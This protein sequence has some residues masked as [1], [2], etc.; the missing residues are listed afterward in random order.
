MIK[1]FKEN[2]IN[3]SIT[4]IMALLLFNA[5]LIFY[6][7]KVMKENTALKKQTEDVQSL[8]KSIFENHLRR[9]DLGLR[10]YALTKK[11]QMLKPYYDARAEMP[12]S[13]SYMDSLLVEQHL[14]DTKKQFTVFKRK[15]EGYTNYLETMRVLAEQDSIEAF[16]QLL[17]EDKGFELWNAYAPMFDYII[18]T[19]H[20]LVQRADARYQEALD[21]NVIFQAILIALTIPTLIGVMYRIRRDVRNR[22]KLLLDFEENNRTYMFNPGLTVS[23]DNQQDIIE[24]SIQNLKKASVFIKGMASGNYS[25]N[26][27]GLTPENE[28]LNQENLAGDLIKLRDEMKKVKETDEKRIWSTEGLA[29]FS[30]VAR[31][32]QNNIEKLSNEVVRFLANYLKA[33]QGS[34]FI[35]HNEEDEEPYLQMAACY[36]FEK[37]KF[38]EKRVEIGSG[39]VGQAYM[40]G[41]TILLTQVPSGYITITSGMGD[42]T[43]NC[44]IIVP[45]KYNDRVEAILE[46]AS[47]SVFQ[48]HEIEF[49]EKA[50]EV[51]ASS[52][53][54][55]KINERTTKLL[56][57]TQHQ[58]EILKAQEEELRQ[59]M[60]E[61]QATQESMR[62][63]ERERQGKG[64]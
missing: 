14:D 3:I 13:L 2:F 9:M 1:R 37:K 27:P 23:T 49:L 7:R 17:N 4:L 59:N 26:W 40:E 42:A 29:K 58:A 16:V 41:E 52:I 32:N 8:W 24:N 21:R 50:G 38:I 20:T 31:N 11:P 47:F 62:R 34:L 61:M 33:Q 10:G 19:Q 45:M 30:D 55:T 56:N 12:V 6:N 36:A 44:V 18:S 46:L 22:K 51:I 57:E 53:F 35:L 54:A 64:N 63:E 15:L 48:S 25:I 43:P 39:M 60:E 5:G 28:A